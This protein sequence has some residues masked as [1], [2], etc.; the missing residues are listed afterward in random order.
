MLRG[1]GASITRGGRV[2]GTAS[3][4]WCCGAED[5]TCRFEAGAQRQSSQRAG[6]QVYSMYCSGGRLWLGRKSEQRCKCDDD[7]GDMRRRLKE[8][9]GV[10]RESS[11]SGVDGPGYLGTGRV[12]APG[13]Q[14]L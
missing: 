12:P 14:R 8:W 3:D 13:K 11:Q 5:S 7:D 2:L 4:D 6:R 1:R 10:E 9:C